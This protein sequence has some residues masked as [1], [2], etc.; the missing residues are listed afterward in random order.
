[1]L[2]RCSATEPLAQP[3]VHFVFEMASSWQTLCVAE[4]ALELLVFLFP[5]V[6]VS[7]MSYCAPF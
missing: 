3:F 1:M 6:R 5:S 2:G 7:G 4:D